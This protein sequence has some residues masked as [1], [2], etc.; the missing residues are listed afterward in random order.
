MARLKTPDEAVRVHC[1]PVQRAVPE[2]ASVGGG[3]EEAL[4]RETERGGHGA[5]PADE[6]LESGAEWDRG[7]VGIRVDSSAWELP[8]G[9]GAGVLLVK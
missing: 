7:V 5:L 2:V 1:E 8:E 3:G 9:A 6:R 4:G